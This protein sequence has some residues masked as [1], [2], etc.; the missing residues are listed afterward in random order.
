MIQS[1]K[2]TAAHEFMKFKVFKLMKPV[3]FSYTEP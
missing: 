1:Q 2:L 3:L